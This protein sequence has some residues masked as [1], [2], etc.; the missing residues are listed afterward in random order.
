MMKFESIINDACCDVRI[1]DGVL[2]IDNPEHV[3]VLQEYLEKAGY[4]MDY[5]VENTAELFEAGRFP[6]RQAYNKDGILV[7]FPSK[8]YRDRAVDKGTHFAENPKKNVGTLYAPGDSGEL[9]T[10]DVSKTTQ[11]GS[12]Q[13]STDKSD[14][15]SLDKELNKKIAGDDKVDNRSTKDKVQDAQAVTAMLV[16]DVPLV[17]YSVDEAVRYGF[18]K[19]GFDWYD[20]DGNF[21][22][23]QVYDEST[24]QTMIQTERAPTKADKS[25]K[26]KAPKKVASKKAEPVAIA[27]EPGKAKDVEYNMAAEITSY[28]KSKKF[29]TKDITAQLLAKGLVERNGIKACEA[30]GDKECDINNPLFAEIKATSKTDCLLYGSGKPMRASLKDSGAQGCS[31]QNYEI[32]AIITTV[33]QETGESQK[34]MDSVTSFIMDGLNK[35]FYVPLKD[36]VKQKL[37]KSLTAVMNGASIA[38]VKKDMEAV[39]QIIKTNKD[40]VVN[41]QIPVDMTTILTKI[42]EVFNQ[43]EKRYLFIEEMLTGKRRFR[44]GQGTFDAVCIADYMMTWNREGNYHLYTVQDFIKGNQ[45]NIKFRFSNRGG[46]RGLA[47]RSDLKVNLKNMFKESVLNEGFTDVLA[48][49]GKSIS[50]FFADVTKSISSLYGEAKAYFTKVWESI[51]KGIADI[52]ETILKFGQFLKQIIQQGWATFADWV[53]I[54]SEAQGTWI[55]SMPSSSPEVA[56][57]DTTPTV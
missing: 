42:N 4:S 36:D 53:G 26:V 31:A 16:S 22:G 39:E 10:A 33:L 35:S 52:Y 2:R 12:E 55:W 27:A 30:L 8:E 18:Y 56:T 49:V 46:V 41:G 9:S 14:T 38:S 15:V 45:N 5:I 54:E 1:K 40:Y 23:E 3:F 21:L 48:Q 20:N 50:T 43:P 19:K 7:T 47:I 24:G 17:N 25:Q 57:S 11:D 6:E 37:Q 32:N 44:S 29:V 51:K 13:D 28:V 34:T